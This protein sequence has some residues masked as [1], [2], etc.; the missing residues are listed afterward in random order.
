MNE[1]VLL[2]TSA[3][4]AHLED[5]EGADEVERYL[6]D[7][8]NDGYR[9]LASFVTLTE[10]RYVTIQRKNEPSADRVVALVKSWPVEWIQSDERL[11]LLAG[12]L[13]AAYRIS[14]ADAFIAATARLTNSTLVHK[15][16]EF[17]SLSAEVRLAP[18][19]YK[20]PPASGS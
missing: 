1:P 9:L 18:L 12:K 19:P 4:I 6:R 7:A 11:C 14:L 20:R 2:D 17:E 16:P 10:L 3:F 5:E 13:K 15:D 8:E